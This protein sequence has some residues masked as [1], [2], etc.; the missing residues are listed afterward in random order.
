MAMVKAFSYGSGSFEIANALQ[1]HHVDYLTVAYS[2]EGVEL[3]KAGINTPIMVMNPDWQSFDS[4]IKYNLEPEIYS[5]RILDLLEKSI[6]VNII[7]ANKPIKIHIKLDTGMHR[8][9]FEENDLDELL[10]R[11]K[12][13]KSVYLQ[14]AFSHLAA[15][16]DEKFDDFTRLQID[17]FEKMSDK[18]IAQADDH[19]VLR[20]I[21]NSAGIGR[22]PEAQF[23]MVRL[24]IGMY[25]I[26][27]NKIERNK[28]ENVSTLKSTISQIKRI[29]PHDSI[30][31]N[32]SGK[33]DQEMIIAIIPVGYA[34][35]ISMSLG[36]GIGKF[37]I[38][39]KFAPIIGN[40]CMDMCM[41]DITDI[42]AAEGDEV[43]IFG[44]IYPIWKIAETIN[45]IPYEIL[46]GIS[47]RV[48]RIYFQE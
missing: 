48:K 14:S 2:D 46:T 32:R 18:I 4:I 11:L 7:P 40:V 29:Q 13:N 20:H 15:S 5:F 23:D 1:F 43:I 39:G 37:G 33:A 26:S 25:G 41:V 28:L 35:G 19:P 42:I 44:E 24:G 8:L 17:R 16:Q 27:S 34:D 21:L 45:T 31:Y 6:K 22:F 47:R 30:G 3:R 9:G 12:D 38:N 10:K 36:N